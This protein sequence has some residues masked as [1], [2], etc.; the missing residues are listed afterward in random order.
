MIYTKALDLDLKFAVSSIH[1]LQTY[2][3]RSVSR[4]L[5]QQGRRRRRRRQRTIVNTITAR[6]NASS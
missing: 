6:W 2:V 1:N 3:F 5:K 4:D